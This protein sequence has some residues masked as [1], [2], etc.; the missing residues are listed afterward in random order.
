MTSYLLDTGFLYALINRS[1][2]RHEEVVAA[3]SAIRGAIVLP[4]PAIT[5]TAYL[6]LRDAGS[7]AA[8][9]FIESL[10]TTKMLLETPQPGDYTRAAEVIR[11]YADSRVDFVDALIVA[12][13]ER[14]SITT[15]LTLD[16]R[17]FRL[18]RPL[19]CEA[20]NLLP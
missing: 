1:E 14:L 18:F 15:I 10:G 13:A 3:T 11:R 12:M 4:V 8:A 20:F 9:D 17:H 6:L 5:E 19:H 2:Q 16:Q 7:R